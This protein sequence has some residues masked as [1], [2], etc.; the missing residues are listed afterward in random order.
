MDKDAETRAIPVV[1][2]GSRP[3]GSL[4]ESY[5]HFTDPMIAAAKKRLPGPLLPA[6][7]R[8][9]RHW[10]YRAENPY[11]EEV[12]EIAAMVGTGAWFMNYC[13]EWGCTTGVATDPAGHGMRMM[14][15]LDWPFHG[16]GR[17]VVVARQRGPAGEFLNITW[18]GFVGVITAMAPGRFALAINQAP[19]VRRGYLPLSMDWMANRVKVFSSSALP[20]AHAARQAMEKC[21]SY[22]EAR[23]FLETIPLALPAFFTLAGTARGDGCVIER[24]EDRAW[25]HRAPAAVANHWL[26]PGLRGRP[27]G[28]DSRRRHRLMNG[29]NRLPTDSFEWL[30]DPIHN[31]ETRLS[32][33]TNPATGDLRVQGWEVDGPA[34]EVLLHEEPAA[35]PEAPRKSALRR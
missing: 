18:P 23:D 22:D 15:T 7:D 6:M 29:F 10:A 11:R 26:T 19:L 31:E 14:R 34:T 16:V 21:R 33:V 35:M 32:V 5:A 3:P 4:M 30:V 24:T 12:G 25:I 8:L 27:R 17:Y 13:F 2:L 9:S 28:V 1:D 20:P